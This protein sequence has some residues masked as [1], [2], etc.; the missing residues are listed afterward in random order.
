MGF[1]ELRIIPGFDVEKTPTLNIAGVSDG[2]LI[3]WREGFP[4]KLGGWSKFFPSAIGDTPRALHAWQDLNG[5]N[6]LAIGSLN[7]LKV[8]T[9][10]VLSDISPQKTVTNTAPNFSTVI[11]TPTVTIIDSNISN[12]SV[13]DWVFLSTPVA[14]GG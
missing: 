10:G 4:E 13:N 11:N 12:P 6:R 5:N 8:I 3:R 14:I 2:Q 7:S 9:G 1:Q